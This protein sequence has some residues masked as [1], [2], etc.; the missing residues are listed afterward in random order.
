[1]FIYLNYFAKLSI[2]LVLQEKLPNNHSYLSKFGLLFSIAIV[3]KKALSS[4]TI[5]VCKDFTMGVDSEY[6]ASN[7]YIL[8][9]L[10]FIITF[11][12]ARSFV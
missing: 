7:S 12:S 9:F 4:Q 11:F 3:I 8:V 6:L 5:Q 2:D 10:E 1:M